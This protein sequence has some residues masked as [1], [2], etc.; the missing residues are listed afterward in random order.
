MS[1][2]VEQADAACRR[3]R[4]RV[5]P[6]GIEGPLDIAD[7][8]DEL[9]AAFRDERAELGALVPPSAYADD[10]NR[11]L[12]SI[13]ESIELLEEAIPAARAGDD[14]TVRGNADKNRER[15]QVMDTFARRVGFT[16]CGTT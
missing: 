13:D 3:F 14:A 7:G 9:L 1:A 16:V 4:E 10:W 5:A 12:R 6:L 15:N 8:G 11:V 2:F